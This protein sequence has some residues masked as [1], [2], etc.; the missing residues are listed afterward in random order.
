MNFFLSCA[1]NR[2]KQYMKAKRESKLNVY[3]YRLLNVCV[4]SISRRLF[5]RRWKSSSVKIFATWCPV[6]PKPGMYSDLFRTPQCL[7]QTPVSAPPILAAGGTVK[8]TEEAHRDLL[9]Q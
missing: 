7:V 9:T 8:A 4:N 5:L 2:T 6:N 3:V 1:Y